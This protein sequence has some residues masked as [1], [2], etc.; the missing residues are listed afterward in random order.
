MVH[1]A[2]H[3]ISPVFLQCWKACGNKRTFK[4]YWWS[5]PVILRFWKM[6]HQTN[7]RIP[8]PLKARNNPV[9][10]LVGTTYKFKQKKKRI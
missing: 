5:C 6:V 4:N 1:D 2:G 3:H 7:Y 9:K 10:L 8:D